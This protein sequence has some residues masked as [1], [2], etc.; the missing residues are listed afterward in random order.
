MYAVL[1]FNTICMLML[2][3]VNIIQKK[4]FPLLL[5]E[6]KGVGEGR[7]IKLNKFFSQL[8]S[9]QHTLY[10]HVLRVTRLRISLKS[11]K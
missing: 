6:G 1:S 10:K 2:S 3:L 9:T 4:V 7:V 5:I 11:V 8:G